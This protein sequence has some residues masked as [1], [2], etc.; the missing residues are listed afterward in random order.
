MISEHEW[1]LGRRCP[2]KILHARAQLP[3]SATGSSLSTW[4]RAESGRL[5]ALAR[6]LFP[7]AVTVSANDRSAAE[8]ET[9]VLV[10]AGRPVSGGRFATEDVRCEVDFIVP[11]GGTLRIYQVVPRAVDL[12]RHRLRLEFTWREGKIRKEWYSHLALMALRLRV[13]QQ[14]WPHHRVL[15][16]FVAPVRDR[17]ARLEGLHGCFAPS[18]DGWITTNP[19]A[20]AEASQLLTMILVAEHCIPLIEHVT[21]QA[22]ALNEWLLKPSAPVL[23]YGC[24]NCEFKVTEGESGFDRCWGPLARVSPHMFDLTY[25]Y[26]IQEGGQPVANR[27]A[28]EGRVSLWDIPV[29]KIVGEHSDRQ[30]MQL[31]V[32]RTGV[33][34][35]YDELKN[36]MARVT[37]PLHF[38]DIETVG[39]ILPVHRGTRAGLNLFQ[40]SVHRRSHV[41]ADLV[42]LEWLNT[43]RASPNRR[44]LSA[45]RSMIGDHGTTLVWTAHEEKS[46]NTL[47]AELIEEGEDDD[48]G[49]LRWLKIYLRSGRIVDQCQMCFRHYIS[50]LMMGRTSLKVVLPAIWSEV[51]PVKAREPYAKFPEGTDPYAVLKAAGQIHEGCGAMTA[52][53]EMQASDGEVRAKL[54]R[55]LLEYCGVDSLVMAFCWDAWA[56]ALEQQDADRV[57]SPE[58]CSPRLAP[59]LP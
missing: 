23:G 52:Y 15:P 10:A 34:L 45:L 26:F 25:M 51:S 6:H 43:E 54:I 1:T 41:G 46:F 3:R 21:R 18:G 13:M 40:L 27:L 31:E 38:L 14:L 56:Y 2:V 7:D 17:V 53:L 22:S 48:D 59:A 4:M 11:D 33:G 20:A 30:L 42:H 44:F 9:R 47:L 58:N 39:P 55:E 50:P 29:E 32:T 36:E 16:F 8:N 12:E 5:H 19:A 24:K 49:D 35:I 37:Y 57:D 28:R